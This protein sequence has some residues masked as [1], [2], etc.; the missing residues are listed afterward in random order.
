[1]SLRIGVAEEQGVGETPG[2]LRDGRGRN[3]EGAAAPSQHEGQRGHWH[4]QGREP[5]V[6]KCQLLKPSFLP[7]SSGTEGLR[8]DLSKSPCHHISH[9]T[10]LAIEQV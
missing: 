8:K 10:S 2:C 1:M 3:G 6:L 9:L 4:I 7:A 5:S